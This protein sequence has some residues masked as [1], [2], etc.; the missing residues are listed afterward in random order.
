MPVQGLQI[1]FYS[2]GNYLNP[3]SPE[4]TGHYVAGS[5][6]WNQANGERVVVPLASETFGL[7]I[8]NQ[9]PIYAEIAL[10]TLEVGQLKIPPAA[11]RFQFAVPP[12]GQFGHLRHNG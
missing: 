4:L 2:R 7:R 10:Q 11:L 9:G 12:Q 8:R 5:E 3:Q 6:S 1:R